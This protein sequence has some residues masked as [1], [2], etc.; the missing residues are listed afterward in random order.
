MP[1]ALAK[2]LAV[3][4]LLN[5]VEVIRDSGVRPISAA[6]R[7]NQ[8]VEANGIGGRLSMLLATSAM[9]FPTTALANLSNREAT[10][11]IDGTAAHSSYGSAPGW[12]IGQPLQ[13]AISW[14][15]TI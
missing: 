6:A 15:L 14:R 9:V 2:G 11:A 8:P 10:S 4:G 5:I 3:T 13:C 12:S 1:T 7:E